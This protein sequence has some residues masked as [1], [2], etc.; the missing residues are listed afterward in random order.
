MA[1]KTALYVVDNPIRGGKRTH[2]LRD[3]GDIW[4]RICNSTIEVKRGKRLGALREI[5]CK[6]CLNLYQPHIHLYK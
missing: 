3:A 6:N 5:N 1:G 2:I 4:V